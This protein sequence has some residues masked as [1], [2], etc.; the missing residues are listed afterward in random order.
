MN[1][2]TRFTHVSRLSKPRTLLQTCERCSGYM[3]PDMCTDLQSDS[4]Q[5]NFWA[6]RCVQCGDIVDEVI[7][8]NRSRSNHKAEFI[9]AA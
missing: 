5:C 9:S 4:G 6:L 3:A 2:H 7:L 8:R 1:A